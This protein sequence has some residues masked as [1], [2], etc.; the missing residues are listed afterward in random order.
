MEFAYWPERRLGYEV[1]WQDAE[2]LT[3]I[4]PWNAVTTPS[5]HSVSNRSLFI[6]SERST[7]FY[8]G[9]GL[10]SAEGEQFAAQADLVFLECEYMVAANGHGSWADIKPLD[11]KA[12]SRW[13]L[14]HIDAASRPAVAEAILPIRASR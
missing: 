2:E 1:L 4:G 14:Y 7:L 8:S 3:Q 9:D 6:T 5:T 13:V 10:L 12:G 11:R